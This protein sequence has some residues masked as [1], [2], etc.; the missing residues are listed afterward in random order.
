[1]L[2]NLFDINRDGTLFGLADDVPKN[3]ILDMFGGDGAKEIMAIPWGTSKDFYPTWEIINAPLFDE[4][5]EENPE[6][7]HVK[8]DEVDLRPLR[9][10]CTD[11][12]RDG[13]LL[14]Y[15]FKTDRR[16][17]KWRVNRSRWLNKKDKLYAKYGGALIEKVEA[18]GKKSQIIRTDEPK[19]IVTK[20]RRLVRTG[21]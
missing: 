17:D 21:L 5:D 2:F 4:D 9:I 12:A 3:I 13:G 7:A 18:Q 20:D 10:F 8:G 14:D 15:T 19:K 11:P 1:M 16:F 6:I